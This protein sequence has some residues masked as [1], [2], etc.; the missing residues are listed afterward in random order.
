MNTLMAIYSI[1]TICSSDD[2]AH[3]IVSSDR[4]EQENNHSNNSS[5]ETKVETDEAELCN[6]D[7]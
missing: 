1:S 2:D 6:E 3:K 4:S 7:K 5:N